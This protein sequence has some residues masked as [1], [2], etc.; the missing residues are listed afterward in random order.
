MICVQN[1]DPYPYQIFQNVYSIREDYK[2]LT[3][4]NLN[5]TK[6]QPC[7][8]RYCHKVILACYANCL[9]FTV[10][11]DIDEFVYNFDSIL[12]FDVRSEL[13]IN[14]NAS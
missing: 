2:F 12:I 3:L 4:I 11:N 5:S 6:L 10:D 13:S 7:Y 1:N 8:I 9:E 14:K